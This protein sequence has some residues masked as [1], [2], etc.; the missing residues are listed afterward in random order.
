MTITNTT[1]GC[2]LIKIM[3]IAKFTSVI[4]KVLTIEH[5][6]QTQTILDLIIDLMPNMI[7]FKQ[8]FLNI[9]V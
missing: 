9:D 6:V 7:F 3:A 2:K 1:F 8:F 4:V 5:E